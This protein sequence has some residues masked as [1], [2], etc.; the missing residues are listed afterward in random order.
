M[1]ALCRRVRKTRRSAVVCTTPE[2]QL[3][4]AKDFGYDTPPL[5]QTWRLTTPSGGPVPLDCPRRHSQEYRAQEAVFREYRINQAKLCYRLPR[6]SFLPVIHDHQAGRQSRAEQSHAPRDATPT[7][8]KAQTDLGKAQR[9]TDS[10]ATRYR[11]C[12]ANSSPP[13]SSRPLMKA[14]GGTGRASRRAKLQARGAQAPRP[15]LSR[16]PQAFRRSARP[17]IQDP[18]GH[19]NGIYTRP[20]PDRTSRSLRY[21]Q[22]PTHPQRPRR[23]HALK[24]SKHASPRRS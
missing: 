9:P 2:N 10:E 14:N 7:M 13:L 20:G 4:R 6:G 22:R 18:A 16:Q 17:R 23:A 21:P 3:T 11:A 15:V 12:R 5:N 24:A 8:D 19:C 1:D